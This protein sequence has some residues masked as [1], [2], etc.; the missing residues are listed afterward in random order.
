MSQSTD[1][2]TAGFM[3]LSESEQQEVIRQINNYLEQ[4]SVMKKSLT[5]SFESRVRAAVLGP[6]NPGGCP[7][8]GR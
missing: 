4:G 2:V 1:F 3:K 5:E 8:C 6:K 7:C